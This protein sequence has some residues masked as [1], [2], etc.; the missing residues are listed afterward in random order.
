[1]RAD[2]AKLEARERKKELRAKMKEEAKELRRKQKELL[3]SAKERARAEM[4]RLDDEL[5][6]KQTTMV[7]DE[8]AVVQLTMDGQ[9]VREYK[10]V[11]DAIRETGLH[12]IRNCV[13]GVQDMAGGFIWKYKVEG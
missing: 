9:F 11:A 3:R 8:H 12:T 7:W 4:R 10:C 6:E 2:Y 5:R 13:K 1:M